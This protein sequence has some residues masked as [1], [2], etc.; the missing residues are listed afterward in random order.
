MTQLLTKG[1][2]YLKIFDV[3]I[4]HDL[5][6]VFKRVV[7]YLGYILKPNQINPVWKICDNIY[8]N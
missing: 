5:K 8:E 2:G 1:F 3:W 7:Q 6:L 4:M